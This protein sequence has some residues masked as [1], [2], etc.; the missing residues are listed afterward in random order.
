M[1]HTL[2]GP[3]VSTAQPVSPPDGE[4]RAQLERLLGSHQFRG[5]KRCHNLLRY[6]TE[7]ALA[8]DTSGLKERTLGVEVFG[9]APDYDS[10]QDPIVRATAAEIR[11]KLAQYYQDPEH[12]AEP[13]ISLLAGSY[14]PEFHTAAAAVAP[15]RK[16][17]RLVAMAGVG[18]AA[19]T[20]LVTAWG[21]LRPRT[22]ALDQFWAPVLDARGDVMICVGQPVVYNMRSSEAQG[23]IQAPPAK[24]GQPPPAAT[25]S[26]PLKDLVI[27]RDRYVALDDAISLV[28]VTS[29][30]QDHRKPFLVRGQASTTFAELSER[31]AVLIGAFNNQW[32]LSVDGQLRFSFELDTIHDIGCIRDRQNPDR[33]EWR[34]NCSW[35][36]WDIP[37]DYAIVSRVFDVNTDR[38]VVVAAGITQFGTVA[39]GEFLTDPQYFSELSP[40][41]PRGWQTRNLQAVLRVPVV[42]GVA[43]HPH[44]VA[45]H[46]W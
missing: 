26:I 15:V 24:N 25:G 7:C 18:L 21:V 40:M 13:R 32:T 27:I 44:V 39:A 1:G 16:R 9:R 30:L 10:N 5:S 4:V 20:L 11:K 38:P 35:P 6:V 17:S 33:R 23:R 36:Y 2:Q 34:V 43:G 31:P 29:F 37:I 28:K 45:T 3:E 42:H 22:A 19:G 14:I 46:I 41:L 12:A 8:G